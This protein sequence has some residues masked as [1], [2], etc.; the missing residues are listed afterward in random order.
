MTNHQPKQLIWCRDLVP[1]LRRVNTTTYYR[2]FWRIEYSIFRKYEPN[3]DVY[4]FTNSINANYS[5]IVCNFKN[6]KI[7]YRIRDSKTFKLRN[8][9]L[10]SLETCSKKKINVNI[11]WGFRVTKISVEHKQE[12]QSCQCCDFISM[13]WPIISSK[14]LNYLSHVIDI[15]FLFLIWICRKNKLI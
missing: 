10:A 15:W 6:K 2:L 12:G 14:F 13:A 9:T 7:S 4:W 11:F 1:T 3:Q 8:K 5:M